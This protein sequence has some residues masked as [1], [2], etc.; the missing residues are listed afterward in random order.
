MSGNA[1]EGIA[2]AQIAAA[3]SQGSAGVKKHHDGNIAY[4]NER[5]IVS[6]LAIGVTGLLVLWATAKS[7][8]VLYGSLAGV[9]A[10]TLLWGYARIKRLEAIRRER[11]QQADAWQSQD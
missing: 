8:L 2:K 4:L 5:I 10:L 11:A 7:A 9:I 1:E 6:L 3:Q